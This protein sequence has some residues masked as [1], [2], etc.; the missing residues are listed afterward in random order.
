MAICG[1]CGGTG[2][3]QAGWNNDQQTT[4]YMTCEVCGGSGQTGN[5]GPSSTGGCA[6]FLLAMVSG[7]LTIL[8]FL[9][10]IL[11]R[12]AACLG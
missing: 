10:G 6:V 4:R 12:F 7:M 1:R 5:D 2:R 8:G 3:L 11:D 9:V